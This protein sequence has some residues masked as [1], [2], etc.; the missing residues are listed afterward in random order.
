MPN[1]YEMNKR[2]TSFLQI[3]SL[4]YLLNFYL[5]IVS[6]IFLIAVATHITEAVSGRKDL[7]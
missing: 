2:M 7:C 1:I 3:L 4:T 5:V 6:V